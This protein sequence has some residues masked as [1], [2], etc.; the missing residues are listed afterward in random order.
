M[1][2]HHLTKHSDPVEFMDA[3][4][5]IQNPYDANAFSFAQIT[6]YTNLKASVANA[7]KGGTCY[8]DFKPFTVK[9]IRQHLGLYVLNGLN[10]S[11]QLSQ[12]FRTQGNDFVAFHMGQN[13]ARKHRHFRAFLTLQDPRKDPPERK[14]SPLFK[15][16]RLVKWLN[17]ISQSAVDLGITLSVDEQTLG[18]QG[19]HPDKARITFKKE[20]DGFLVDVICDN[21]YTYSCYFRMEPAPTKYT[22]AGLSPLHARVL[23]LF[24][25]LRDNYHR[26]FMDNLYLSAKFCRSAYSHNRKV[27]IAGVTRKS[28]RG[29]PSSVVQEEKINKSDQ[30]KVKG[31]VKAAVLKGD[32]MCPDLLAV[33]V[34]DTKPVHFLTMV[35]ERIEWITKERKV[36]NPL[37][38]TTEIVKFLRLNV[39][40]DYNNDMGHVDVADQLRNQYRFDHW[41]RN[42]K[43]WWSVLLWALGVL[44][45]NAY[46]FYK[47][48]MEEERVP[49]KEWLTHYQFREAIAMAWIQMD[50]P[51][52][53]ERR[54]MNT[55][56]TT[57]ANMNTPTTS[58]KRS[59]PPTTGGYSRRQTKKQKETPTPRTRLQSSQSVKPAVAPPLHD[60]TI[61]AQ[62]GPYSNRL[63]RFFDHFPEEPSGK[64]PKCALHRYASGLEERKN[65]VACMYCKIHLCV[66]CFATFHTEPDLLMAKKRIGNELQAIHEASKDQKE[67]RNSV[68]KR[69]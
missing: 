51:T 7:G 52:I 64:R 21:G 54:N 59:S 32:P 18:M 10:P 49:K 66:R 22:N 36:Y 58:T 29:L 33:S 13:A 35:A 37:T 42:Y 60:S 38:N 25:Q 46:V 27:L 14:K 45:V 50:E 41:K 12:K 62:H 47:T 19:R 40:D 39:N 20:G 9:E 34:Y 57:T 53:K 61:M 1:R 69:I 23:W 67:A 24:D 5:P 63:N 55:Q 6:T 16:S 30:L 44:T 8:Q 15:V 68:K 4:F 17:F 3:F 31:T 65:I 26:V 48:V 2:K 28:G 11:P 43:W 56:K